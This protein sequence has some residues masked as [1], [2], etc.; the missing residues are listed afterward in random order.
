MKKKKQIK[1][2]NWGSAN[3]FE[4][5]IELNKN[6]KN[7]PELE[8]IILAHEETH[9][10]KFD[11]IHEFDYSIWKIFPKLFLFIVFHPSTWVDFLPIQYKNKKL[12]F[13]INLCILYGIFAALI[14]LFITMM[15][16]II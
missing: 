10:D 16:S 11:L 8:K 12:V 7:Y 9:T 13:D 3:S 6:L 5:R 2:I 15:K 1:Y 4:D 14:V